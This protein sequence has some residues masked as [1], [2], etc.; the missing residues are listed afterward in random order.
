[1][2]IK[3]ENGFFISDNG[4]IAVKNTA[5]TAISIF[6]HRY[7]DDPDSDF[8]DLVVWVDGA[9]KDED[10]PLLHHHPLAECEAE[11]AVIIANC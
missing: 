11:R 3:F 7:A 2:K 8:Y 10:L 9:T 5:I 1:M 6:S 4:K